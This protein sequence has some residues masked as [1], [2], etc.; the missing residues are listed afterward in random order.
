[1]HPIAEAHKLSLAQVALAWLLH[2]RAVTFVI[3]E[4]KR[5]KQPNDN[6]GSVAVKL[7]PDKLAAL[8]SVSVL[9]T[10]YSA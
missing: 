10:E 8:A 7:I 9:P 2:H 4:V 1:M 6:L 3:T 5:L